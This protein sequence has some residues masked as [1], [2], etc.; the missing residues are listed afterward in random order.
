MSFLASTGRG[1]RQPKCNM[2]AAIRDD[3]TS[4]W[5]D[6]QDLEEAYKEI[7]ANKIPISLSVI[8]FAVKSHHLGDW[9]NFF[10]EQS[11]KAIGENP[12]LIK[13]LSD[14]LKENKVFLMLHGFSH[15]Y[16]VT[17]NKKDKAI[18]ATR[19]N[20]ALLRS[21]RKVTP[22]VW[23]GEYNWKDYPQLKDETK[24]GKD[25]LEDLFH[26]K[27]TVFVPPSNDISSGAAK[28]VAENGLNI[29]GTMRISKF[30]RSLD[31]YSIRNWTLKLLWRMKY[32]CVYPYVMSY[33][34]HKELSAFGLIPNLAFQELREKIDLCRKKDA[35]FVMATHHWEVKKNKNLADCLNL[36]LKYLNSYNTPYSTL[37]EIFN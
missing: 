3:D 19:E 25:Y 4:Y 34:T 22:L 20:L 15:Q 14:K 6:P 21:D 35:P 13:F 33:G 5:T 26:Q 23:F 8:P 7:W 9:N 24:R 18:L 32:N 31:F 30:N 29:S 11:L 37:G 17:G 10:Q 27:I 2:I 36:L 12:D 28:A 1:L 16:K